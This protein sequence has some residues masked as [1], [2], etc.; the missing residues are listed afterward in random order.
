MPILIN[1]NTAVV[2]Y[3]AT[4]GQTVFVVPYE[5]F[6]VGDLKVYNGDTLLA[7]NASP[8][9][10]SQYSV[11]GAGVTGGGS[12]TLGAPGASVSNVITIS[13]DIPIKR[14]TDFP[15]AGPFNIEALNTEL[16]KQIAMMQELERDIDRSIAVPLGESSLDLPSAADRANRF[17][18]FDGDGN[19]LAALGEMGNTP[20]GAFGETLVSNATAADARADLSVKSIAEYSAADGATYIGFD[21]AGTSPVATSV[22]SKLLEFDSACNLVNEFGLLAAHDAFRKLETT[23]TSGPFYVGI[24]GYGDSMA[25]PSNYMFGVMC[26]ALQMRYGVGGVFSPGLGQTF[27][28]ATWAF[29]GGATQPRNDYTYFPGA[30]QINMPAGSTASMT[31]AVLSITSITRNDGTFPR[32]YDQI[33]QRVNFTTQFRTVR[34]FYL[35][36]PGDGSLTFTLSQTSVTGYSPVVV[37]CNA[38]LEL[39]YTDITVIDRGAPITL[40]VS[41]S[42]ATCLFVGAVF[43]RES[44]VLA[45]SSQVGGSTM[46]QQKTY[47][48]NGNYSTTYRQ[49]CQ[50]LSTALFVHAQRVTP[51]SNYQTNYTQVFDALD[52]IPA[53]SQFVLGEP[54]QI[55][56]GTPNVST[57]NNYLRVTCLSRGYAFYDQ[58]RALGGTTAVLTT[59]GWGDGD[60]VHLDPPA[61]RYLAGKILKEVDFFRIGGNK[62]DASPLTMGQLLKQMGQ[63]QA[64]VNIGSSTIYARAGTTIDGGTTSGGYTYVAD[65]SKGFNFNSAAAL[66]ASA[67]RVGNI[68]TNSPFIRTTDQ[69]VY[70]SFVGF[71]NL[72]L[73]A[74]VRAFA[75]FGV[76]STFSTLTTLNQRC[77]GFECAKGSDVGSPGGVTTEVM[78]LLSSN[79]TTTVYGPWVNAIEAGTSPTSQTGL[80][81]VVGWNRRKQQLELYRRAPSETSPVSILANT[82]LTANMTAG[83]WANL[84]IVGEDAGNVPVATGYFAVNEIKT[85]ADNTVYGLIGNNLIG[86]QFPGY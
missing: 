40:S 8:S 20:V 67:G 54:P 22:D 62:L 70:I 66:G 30:N 63:L 34:C 13:R 77:F 6:E 71:R 68:I 2:Q 56:A 15:N 82:D 75:L 16:D 33:D 12:I 49:L 38:A 81:I 53:T 3:T 27:L 24:T 11:I 85:N 57:I 69:S 4:S 43:L 25:D 50:G 14:V 73:P 60:G 39:A 61:W 5:F 65:N 10:A 26:R 32:E 55:P 76:T 78:R 83:A 9:S 37:S 21:P 44:G 80:N 1:D 58:N 52:T 41:S 18:A 31:T 28:G 86:T 23:A 59:L 17:F 84:A 35:K 74:G 79:G 19:P 64:M 47:I 48:T 46:E 7:Y 72:S 45:W 42:G 36:R 29:G 51:D